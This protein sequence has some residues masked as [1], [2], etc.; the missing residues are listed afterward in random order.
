VSETGKIRRE[1]DSIEKLGHV[2]ETEELTRPTRTSAEITLDL[3]AR[4]AMFLHKLSPDEVVMH[5]DTWLTEVNRLSNYFLS[6]FIS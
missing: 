4:T 5:G 2:R 6:G 1:S 3:V